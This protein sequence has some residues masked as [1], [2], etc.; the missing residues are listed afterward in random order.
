MT[1]AVLC[2]SRLFVSLQSCVCFGSGFPHEVR[3]RA[4][5]CRITVR[6]E[7]IGQTSTSCRFN[8]PFSDATRSSI[9]ATHRCIPVACPS[10][11][12]PSPLHPR[13]VPITCRCIPMTSLLHVVYPL[14]A[15]TCPVHPCYVSVSWVS[16]AIA[17]RYIPVA[18]CDTPVAS[19]SSR[20]LGSL[21]KS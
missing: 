20:P 18:R 3:V 9:P 10:M 1:S 15:V 17:C 12:G 7:I 13:D 21:Q 2:L 8:S 14:H 16:I 6:N 4:V 19:V 11:P 5:Y